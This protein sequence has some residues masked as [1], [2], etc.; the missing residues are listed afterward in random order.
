MALKDDSEILP[1]LRAA[2][3]RVTTALR[4]QPNNSSLAGWGQFLNAEGH[5]E[6]IGP[7][8]CLSNKLSA[9]FMRRLWFQ[10]RWRRARD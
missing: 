5:K 9:D 8:R 6:Q 1:L 7:Y 4:P 2:S 10:G 3:Q